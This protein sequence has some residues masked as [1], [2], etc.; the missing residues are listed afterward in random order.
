MLSPP[1]NNSGNDERSNTVTLR[2]HDR[3]TYERKGQRRYATVQ[4]D[5][6]RCYKG[7]VARM[8]TGFVGVQVSE[9]EDNRETRWI[10][11][12]DVE[13]MPS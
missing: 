9:D 12:T 4:P 6:K 13:R 10:A 11:V 2:A 1:R 3:V 5:P 7:R 8:R